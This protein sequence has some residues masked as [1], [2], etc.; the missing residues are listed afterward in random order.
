MSSP[1]IAIVG[2]GPGGLAAAMLLQASGARVTIYEAQPRIGGRTERVEQEGFTFDRGPTFFLMPHVLDELFAATGR[3]LADFAD[4]TRLDPMYRLVFARA[5]QPAKTLDCTQDLA[6]MAR[7]I[8]AF[9]ASPGDGDRF[10]PYMLDNRRKLALFEPI[11]RGSFPNFRSLLSLDLIK[12]ALVLHPLQSVHSQLTK[13]FDDPMVR[14]ALCFQAKYLGMSPFKCPSLFSILPYIEYQFGVWHPRGGCNALMSAM[15]GAVETMGAEIKTSTPVQRILFD[16]ARAVGVHAAG[17]DQRHD[18]VIMNA[19][20]SWA[21]QNLVPQALRPKWRDKKLQGM[22]YSCSAL[23]LYLGVRGPI[24][25]P[26]HTICVAEDYP[27]NIREISGDLTLSDDPSFYI[28]NPSRTD[29]TLAPPGHSSLYVLVPVP[30]LRSQAD[31]RDPATLAAVRARALDRVARIIGEDIRPRIVTESTFTP[32]DWQ[33]RNIAF[34]AT[35]NFGHGLMQML[36]FRPQ[37]HLPTTS[38]LWLVGGGTHP[39]SGLPVIF[40]SAQAVARELCKRAGLEYAGDVAPPQRV[41]PRTPG[42]APV[43]RV[44]EVRAA[45]ASEIKDEPVRESSTVP[46]A[47]SSPAPLPVATP[48]ATHADDLIPPL[49]RGPVGV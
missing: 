41:M 29:P 23:M 3:R 26:H 2:A 45:L 11:L 35:F 21:L 34:G 40:L 47:A 43:V 42:V 13:R 5:G 16:G 49:F 14:L 9:S 4:L 39:G 18:H 37:H 15:A 1:S 20:A 38:N 30:N 31:W 36:C 19:D 28:C 33:G 17:R 10:I 48:A 22:D 7:R 27:K 24:D 46:A 44:P 25:L 32:A 12:S 6:E 8:A